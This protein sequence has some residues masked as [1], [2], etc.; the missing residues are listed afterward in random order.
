MLHYINKPVSQLQ[1]RRESEEVLLEDSKENPIIHLALFLSQSMNLEKQS[2]SV[3][4]EPWP[5]QP[6]FSINVS[7]DIKSSEKDVKKWPAVQIYRET[8]GEDVYRIIIELKR[9]STEEKRDK[10]SEA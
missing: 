6:E 1:E 8:D 4:C 7:L 10:D 5:D 9:P 3:S 2:A